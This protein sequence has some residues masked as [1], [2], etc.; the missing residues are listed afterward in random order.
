M[1]YSLYVHVGHRCSMSTYRTTAQSFV[2]M[3]SYYCQALGLTV[4]GSCANIYRTS[5]GYQIIVII[6][7]YRWLNRPLTHCDVG[8]W[9]GVSTP[10]RVGNSKRAA[11]EYQRCGLVRSISCPPHTKFSV[12][13][14]TQYLIQHEQWKHPFGLNQPTAPSAG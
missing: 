10:K 11:S 4:C 7:H 14:R 13:Q 1:F 3:R 6:R 5:V 9:E 8:R 12:A 2:L